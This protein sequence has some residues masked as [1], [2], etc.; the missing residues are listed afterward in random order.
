MIRRDHVG[1]PSET[2][3]IDVGEREMTAA[4]RKR[5]CDGAA[6]ATRRTRHHGRPIFQLHIGQ[7]GTLRSAF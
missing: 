1:C 7:A 5:N 4:A 3:F 2:Q 6:N